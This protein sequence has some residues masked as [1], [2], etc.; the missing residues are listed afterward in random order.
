MNIDKSAINQSKI[1]SPKRIPTNLSMSE[2]SLGREV[3]VLLPVRKGRKLSWRTGFGRIKEICEFSAIIEHE[4]GSETEVFG[5]WIYDSEDKVPTDWKTINQIHTMVALSLIGDTYEETI[6]NTI[7]WLM[8][9]YPALPKRFPLA[10]QLAN[11]DLTGITDERFSGDSPARICLQLIQFLARHFYLS[12]DAYGPLWAISRQLVKIEEIGYAWTVD[13]I[14]DK[15]SEHK[16][17]DK[18]QLDILLDLH[19][20]GYSV[21]AQS[22]EH[23]R[24]KRTVQIPTSVLT[25]MV[26]TCGYEIDNVS[27][28]TYMLFVR[29]DDYNKKI[30][31]D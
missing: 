19:N 9:G 24:L 30:F 4:H 17:F 3:Y 8:V 29:F 27:E 20:Q 1:T 13:K 18:S 15:C 6:S 16:S 28:T 10:T 25:K 22:G 21:L 12:R 26:E 5:R 14:L 2:L 31:W 23:R 7:K 11:G